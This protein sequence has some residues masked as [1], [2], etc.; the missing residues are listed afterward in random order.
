MLG[1]PQLHLR[2]VLELGSPHMEKVWPGV[3]LTLTFSQLPVQATPRAPHLH[4]GAQARRP[5]AVPAHRQGSCHLSVC[6]TTAVAEGQ[7]LMPVPRPRASFAEVCWAMCNWLS[8]EK[9][10]PPPF[11]WHLGVHAVNT[12][13]VD[14]KLPM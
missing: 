9:H 3:R 5:P 2:G 1:P 14:V 12:V 13:P 6:L 7:G 8:E 4:T 10:R 11:P